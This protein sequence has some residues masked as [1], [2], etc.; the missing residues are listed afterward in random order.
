VDLHL[1]RAERGR[2]PMTAVA[3]LPGPGQPR[4]IVDFLEAMI[5]DIGTLVRRDALLDPRAARRPGAEP[6]D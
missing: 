2:R 4:L 3:E 1:G 6:P 5:V